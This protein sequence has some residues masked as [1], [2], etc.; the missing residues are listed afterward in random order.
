M[1]KGQAISRFQTRVYDSVLGEDDDDRDDG[2]GGP[3]ELALQAGGQ[4][5]R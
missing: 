4:V 3:Q 5:A 1:E 2:G